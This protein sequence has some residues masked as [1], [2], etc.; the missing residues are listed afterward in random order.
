MEQGEMNVTRG[1]KVSGMPMSQ[2][3]RWEKDCKENYG[4][5]YWLKLW[6]DHQKAKDYDVFVSQILAKF[7]EQ[8]IK[9][10][11]IADLVKDED[12]KERKVKTLGE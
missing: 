7:E 11:L 2:W 3:L 9:I 4:D 5:C 6:N 1:F 10:D 8:D 12:K